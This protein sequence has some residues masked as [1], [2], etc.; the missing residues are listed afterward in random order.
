MSFITIYVTH[1][2]EIEAKKV[3]DYLLNKKLIACY[4]LFPITSSYWWDG[5]IE[6]TS[7]FVTLLKTKTSNWKIIKEEI[8]NIH[9]YKIPCIMKTKVEANKEYEDWIEKECN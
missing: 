2:S 9:P 5:K 7:E 6:N 1:E 3:W 8:K 4:N